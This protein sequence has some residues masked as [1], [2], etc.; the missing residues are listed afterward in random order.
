MIS[1][2]ISKSYL[3]P[4]YKI[5]L[6]EK[7]LSKIEPSVAVEKYQCH[8]LKCMISKTIFQYECCKTM[9]I[10]YLLLTVYKNCQQS[11]SSRLYEDIV[12]FHL[13]IISFVERM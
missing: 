11:K 10:A 12:L 7:W 13:D 4:L 3:S 9:H 2:I 1:L 6:K 5:F 8:F